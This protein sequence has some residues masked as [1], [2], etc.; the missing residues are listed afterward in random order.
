MYDL[1]YLADAS[2][3]QRAQKELAEAF[4]QARV[5]DAS[6]SI[7]HYRLCIEDFTI[8]TSD[9]RQ[10]ILELGMC[11]VSFDFEFFTLQKP[12][13]ALE[14]IKAWQAGREEEP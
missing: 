14:F 12:K 11:N 2:D 6:N 9:Y 5:E 13:E 1:I 3:Y 7:D 8:E 10:K 4:P